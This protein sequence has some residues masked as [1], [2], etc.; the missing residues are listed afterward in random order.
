MGLFVFL[1]AFAPLSDSRVSTPGSTALNSVHNSPDPVLKKIRDVPD[2]VAMRQQI[3]APSAV[4]V[5]IQPAPKDQIRGCG[6]EDTVA[7]LLVYSCFTRRSVGK[8]RETHRMTIQV[9]KPQCSL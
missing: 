8:E 3:P 7:Q 2:G 9:K 6:K 1:N 4:A 5:V